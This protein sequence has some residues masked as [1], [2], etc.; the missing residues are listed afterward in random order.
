MCKKRSFNKLLLTAAFN[1]LIF[2]FIKA[3]EVSIG[4]TVLD[5]SG[6]PVVGAE[7]ELNNLEITNI[8]DES[9]R[10]LLM[11]AVSVG[12][13]T[14]NQRSAVGASLRGSDILI[15]LKESSPVTISIYNL[16]GR[17]VY[18]FDPGTLN[19]GTNVISLPLERFGTGVY[20]ISVNYQG[21]RELFRYAL[22]NNS[23]STKP[24]VNKNAT[25]TAEAFQ[26]TQEVN[27]T[28]IVSAEGFETA[29]Y[30]IDSYTLSGIE[31][32]LESQNGS[33]GSRLDNITRSCGDLMPSP[34]SGGQSAWA[35]R[36][37]DCCKPHCS[38]AENVSDSSKVCA[39]CNIDDEEIKAWRIIGDEYWTGIEGLSSGC[40]PGGET[41]T[42][43]NHAPFAICDRLA[44]G[45]AA[46]PPGDDVCGNC[47]QLDFDGGAENNDVK[48]A[49]EMVKGKTM[50]VMASNI[51]HDVGSGQFDIMIPGGGVGAFPAG[52]ATQWDVDVEDESIVGVKFGG[53]TSTC[54][55]EHGWDADPEDLKECVRTMCD[56]L[57]GD[58]PNRKYL[59]EGCIWY[60]DWMHAVDNPTFVYQEVP[61]PPEL[62]ALY[63]SSFH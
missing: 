19:A 39:N 25:T 48:P 63:Y 54:Q 53:F 29:R 28:I 60:V 20:M 1:L 13:S 30:P 37:W 55:K 57:F 62:E 46:V 26:V 50:I 22:S 24:S 7:V 27:D 4:G 36:Y 49:H 31:I 61:C 45:F 56:N 3:D 35:S 8:T 17:M 2:N 12:R 40:E 47:Y 41:F 34:V 23:R 16:S 33:G 21:Q 43:Y 58:D 38:W 14:L 18:D 9:G 5:Q 15:S 32:I 52:C 51:G 59:W 42:C 11:G 44:Y 10:F 6:N